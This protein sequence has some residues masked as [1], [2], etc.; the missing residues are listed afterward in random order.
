MKKLSLKTVKLLR[1]VQ[2]AI[3]AE[4]KK[5]NMNEFVN[6]SAS[7]IETNKYNKTPLPPCGTQACIAGWACLIGD[8]K[9]NKKMKSILVSI[10]YVGV[11][12]AGFSLNEFKKKAEQLLGITED[13]GSNLFYFAGWGTF[14]ILDE[15]RSY[16]YDSKTGE[17][18]C[19]GWPKKFENAYIKART[20]RGRALA[21]S[22]RIDH[23]IAT[24]G[25]K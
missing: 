23:F 24:N 22:R 2:A 3:L 11:Q 16:T 20:A 13:Q 19:Y 10:D 8:P 1:K 14:P 21:T 9:L 5:V 12:D 4:P 25:A 15:N 18:L 6:M 7:N 17:K